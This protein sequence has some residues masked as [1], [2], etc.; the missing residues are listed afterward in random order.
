MAPH[1]DMTKDKS[2]LQH[3]RVTDVLPSTRDMWRNISF[4]SGSVAAHVLLSDNT[5]SGSY[6]ALSAAGVRADQRH[7]PW[8]GQHVPLPQRRQAALH[9]HAR[10]P[11]PLRPGMCILNWGGGCN[12]C[13]GFTHFGQV[14]VPGVTHMLGYPAHFGQVCLGGVMFSKPS[15]GGGG[16]APQCLC[17]ASCW[18]YHRWLPHRVPRQSC[19]WLIQLTISVLVVKLLRAKR[20]TP[21]NRP[22]NMSEHLG[23]R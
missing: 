8:G 4:S 23:P 13:L 12:T 16:V 18:K 6:L 17:T 20:T 14:C 9:T 22:K 1:P 5:I 10:L 15:E 7:V 21:I 11:R 2:Q 3:W 19:C